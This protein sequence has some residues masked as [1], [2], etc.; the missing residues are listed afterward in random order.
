MH[1][2]RPA[3]AGARHAAILAMIKLV[4]LRRLLTCCILGWSWPAVAADP[5]P[6]APTAA[7]A[8]PPTANPPAAAD[9]TA[10]TFPNAAPAAP[11]PLLLARLS[12]A[13]LASD[14]IKLGDDAAPI[15]ARY[16]KAG[17]DPAKG[18][19]LFLPAPGQFIGDDAVIAA[20]LR[21][22]PAAGWSVLA[23]QLPLLPAAATTVDYA[24]QHDEALARA[25]AALAYLGRDAPPILIV[26]GRADNVEV[27]RELAGDGTRSGVRAVAA[28][29]PWAGKV[30]DSP[31]PLF[32]LSADRD[33]SLLARADARSQEARSHKH[34]AYK[35]FILV[36]ADRHYHGFEDEIARRIQGWAE[37]LPKP[38]A[39]AA[40]GS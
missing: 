4:T 17:R 38:P 22:L 23:V 18:A 29:G 32:D 3:A 20:A 8:S 31:L 40:H 21:L 5:A 15:L 28:L 27:A 1:P 26:I 10:A 9:P 39:H 2:Y 30:G 36:G 6:A 13:T 37:H 12:A 11:E 25:G 14:F 24:A 7:A 33:S 19:A 34:P 35:Q 16:A